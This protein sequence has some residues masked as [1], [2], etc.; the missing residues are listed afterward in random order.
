MLLEEKP[1]LNIEEDI[2][3][4]NIFKDIAG[5][6]VTKYLIFGLVNS[7]LQDKYIAEDK[8]KNF[9]FS[10]FTISRAQN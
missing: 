7:Y 8:Q 9:K 10:N 1:E 3:N 6:A 2:I 4:K 5:I